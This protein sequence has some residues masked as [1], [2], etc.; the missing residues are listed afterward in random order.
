MQTGST[1]EQ[2]QYQEGE[3]IFTPGPG[4]DMPSRPILEAVSW[5][6]ATELVRRFPDRLL[7]I[8]THPGGGQYDCISLIDQDQLSNLRSIDLNRIG[9]VWVH[10]RDDSDWV[11]RGCWTELLLVDDSRLPLD[12]LCWQAGLAAVL[13]LP[14]ATRSVVSYRVIS[15]FLTHQMLGRQRWE[16]RNGFLDGSGMSGGQRDEW[17]DRIP[18]AGERMLVSEPSD[19]FGQPAYRFW[20]LL[21]DGEPRLAIEPSRGFAYD[22][23]G[24]TTNLFARYEKA[25]RIWP[26]V[27]AAAGHLLP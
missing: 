2:H 22:T 9:S 6:L 17:F 24:H 27:W 11:W 18:A 19:P 3:Y 5:R 14:N 23:R 13:R 10:R 21:K 4:Q 25:R 12:R 8:E 15:A 7:V 20:F 26:V 1:G 16:C